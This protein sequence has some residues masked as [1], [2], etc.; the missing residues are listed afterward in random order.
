MK[1]VGRLLEAQRQAERDFVAEAAA[2][3]TAPSNGWTPALTMFHIARWRGRLRHAMSEH[4]AGRP[5]EPPPGSI[6]ELNDTE[7]AEGAGLALPTAAG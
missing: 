6:D 1:N 2:E 4:A 5:F 3:S 7:L